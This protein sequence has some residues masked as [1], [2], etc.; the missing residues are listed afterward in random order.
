VSIGHGALVVDR[1]ARLADVADIVAALSLEASLGNPSIVE[2]SV[3]AAKPVPGQATS[4]AR[5]RTLLE[6]SRLCVPGGAPSVQDPLS[7]RV[8]PQVHGAVRELIADAIAAVDGELAAM[9]DNPLVVIDEGRM[10]SNG[11][12]HPILM[13]LAIDALRP[14]VA[15]LAQLSDRRTGQQF[16]RIAAD[17]AI[18]ASDAIAKLSRYGTPLLR[19]S[20]AARVAELR[21]LAGPATLDVPPLDVGVEDHATNAPLAVRRTDEALGLAEEILAAELLTAAAVVGLLDDGR[22]RLAERTRR[23]LDAIAAR[24]AGLGPGASNDLVH[25]AGVELLGG[26]LLE[27]VGPLDP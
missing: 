24:L 23:T 21:S 3:A 15:H 4:A 25:A 16:D 10:V 26:P 12:F 18:V 6:G 22:E 9:D 11:N 7:F 14:A 8:I 2:P 20:S 13:A 5:I 1:A 17:P 19:Y 27:A